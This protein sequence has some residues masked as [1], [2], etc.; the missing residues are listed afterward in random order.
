VTGT[1]TFPNRELVAEKEVHTDQH[2]DVIRLWKIGLSYQFSINNF[3]SEVF[4]DGDHF[5]SVSFVEKIGFEEKR[6]KNVL[7]EL[8]LLLIKCVPSSTIAIEDG[9]AVQPHFEG[10]TVKIH[11]AI[12]T[13]GD[14][15]YVS[16]ILPCTV[17]KKSKTEAELEAPTEEQ[18]MPFLITSLREKIL[19]DRK[20]LAKQGWKLSYRQCMLENRWSLKFIEAY[21][22][23][24]TV[25]PSKVYDTV[26]KAWRKYL[27]LDEPYYDLLS[28]W[29]IG[30]YFFHL[31]NTYPY[32]YF[33]GIKRSGK[34]KALT[35]ASVLSFNAIFSGNVSTSSIFRLIQSGRCTFLI[36]ETEKLANPDRAQDF[37]GLLLC[38]YK[39][40]SLI[41]RTEKTRREQHIPEAFE[42]FSPKMLANI[43]GLEDVLED[44]CI[45]ITMKRG[46][47][48]QIINR[49]VEINDPYWQE[50]RDQLYILFLT[51]WEQVLECY[52]KLSELGEHN[53]L[54]EVTETIVSEKIGL[55]GREF[56]LWKPLLALASFFDQYV[57]VTSLGSS[58]SLYSLILDMAKRKTEE[59]NIESMTETGDYILAQALL[60]TVDM[61]G[62]YKVKDLRDW[63][64]R[65]FDE[66]QK[67]LNTKWVGNA[68]KRLGFVNK[69]RVGTGYEYFLTVK[70]V[71]DMAERMGIEKQVQEEELTAIEKIK[72]WIIE[73]KDEDGTINILFLSAF[74]VSHGLDPRETIAHLKDEGFLRDPPNKAEYLGKLLVV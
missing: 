52:Q 27:E 16:T 21:L 28:L 62:Y 49:E 4:E 9:R 50:L 54:S 35:L 59:K 26:N 65:Q 67:W 64:A 2:K 40:G 38:G 73:N 42:I 20:V 39:K 19:A 69:R 43:Q 23:G 22:S 30:T 74:I 44:R 14:R 1:T 32:I 53:E 58:H 8:W 12:G 10:L 60:S 51:H 34:T 33:G 11:P 46:R 61:D 70:T 68:L 47:N 18:E 17:T 63:M 25:D 55:S 3:D 37:R 6:L 71:K 5:N 31:F 7:D 48:R 41:Y 72:N 24:A 57:S 45:P 15:A 13:I 66:E 29:I 36:D 56:E